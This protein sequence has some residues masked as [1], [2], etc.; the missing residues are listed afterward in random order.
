MNRRTPL[1]LMI[2]MVLLG[3]SLLSSIVAAQAYTPE[4]KK[5]QS[6]LA[7]RPYISKIN[8]EGNHYFSD[9]EIRSH[10]FSRERS[11][12]QFLKSGSRD[13]VLRYSV[14][15]DTLEV[16]YLYVRAGFLE[17]KIAETVGIV[18]K[19]SSA[20]ITV[21]VDE[22]T[23]FRIGSVQLHASDTM[24]FYSDL[25][26]V[27]AQLKAGE[28]ID[29]FAVKAAVFDL[30]T[31]Y[32]NNGYPYASVTDVFDSSAGASNTVI[33]LQTTAGPPVYF[34]DVIIRDLKYYSPYLARR[35]M[36]FK[37]GNL[38]SREKIIESQ[39]RLYATGL[40]NSI[41]LEIASSDTNE[42]QG[43]RR[44]DTM[45]NFVFGAIERSP[46]FVSVNTGASQDSLQD[47]TWDFTAAWGKRNI[48]VSRKIE[49][50][51][52]YRFIV[53]TQWRLLYHRYQV[54]YTEPW[55]LAFRMPLTLTGRFEPGVRSIV[56]PY[57]IQ[58]W[59][60]ALSTR[61]EW[62][63]QTYAIISGRYENVN[64]YGIALKNQPEFRFE[65][66]ISVRRKLDV[67][68]VHDTRHDKFVPRSG[69][70][71]TYFA[72]YVGGI[73][74]G[75][76]SFYKFEFSW[77]RYQHMVAQAIYATRLK[78]GWVKE[79]GK[80][81]EVPSTDRFYLGGANSIRGFKENSIGPRSVTG[82][83]VGANVY[84]IFNQ[85]IRTPLFWKFWGT[86]FTDM[87]NGWGSFSDIHL[88]NIL[89]SYGAGIQ[90]LSPAGPIRLDYAHHLENGPYKEGDRWHFTILYAF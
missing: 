42:V 33:D 24:P 45:P 39:R 11:F 80:S 32:A 36:D 9:S 3:L 30:K 85:E 71:T 16:K 25:V 41:S 4:E 86:I 84:G 73:L 77:A 69:S 18:P 89:F 38:Y 81:H 53:F 2:A 5:F 67:T 90:F 34:G 49:F 40:F 68:L 10:L 74:G 47:L 54:Q 52:Q 27:A 57:R 44:A 61:K 60:V 14:Y 66:G 7:K 72:Q 65:E 58:T 1:I 59:S 50:S 20:V 43:P 23:Q 12:W 79:F 82:V 78:A 63:E 87:G 62:S 35:E 37:K 29:P 6:W 48:F 19:D 51:L 55:F 21:T 17:I 56:Q 75:D 76:D 64:I 22:G 26:K 8:V 13:R 15:R 83:N 88:E 28:P 31:I 46:H 70:F